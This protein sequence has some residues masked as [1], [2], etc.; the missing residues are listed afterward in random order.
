M[1][2]FRVGRRV[3]ASVRRQQ[4]E[5][6]RY[7]LVDGYTTILAGNTNRDDRTVRNGLAFVE[8]G[9]AGH[10]CQPF[11]SDIFVAA[12][13]GNRR[14]ADIGVDCGCPFGGSVEADRP[15]SICE[16][17]PSAQGGAFEL[18]S[19]IRDYRGI[20]SLQVPVLADPEHPR[21]L[22]HRRAAD[23]RWVDPLELLQGVEAVL[24]LPQLGLQMP[25][26]ALHPGISFSARPIGSLGSDG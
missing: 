18:P 22:V 24:S 21:V 7:E 8:N 19:R 14:H 9:L 25:L 10:R 1:Q 15:G 20:P 4:R 3:Y 13:S 5:D 16:V 17:L 23:S 11:T 26:T 12:P 2:G 6:G